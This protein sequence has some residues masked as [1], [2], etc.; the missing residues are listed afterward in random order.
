MNDT[1]LGGI[2]HAL[3]GQAC[4]ATSQDA[5][6][7]M[8][9]DNA[10]KIAEYFAET[11][12]TSPSLGPAISRAMSSREGQDLLRSFVAHMERPPRDLNIGPLNAC[13]CEFQD[14]Q[15]RLQN[16]I[17]ISLLSWG[18]VCS[19]EEQKPCRSGL[20]PLLEPRRER[21]QTPCSKQLVRTKGAPVSLFETESTPQSISI[22]HQWKENIAK[23]MS[24]DAQYHSEAILR[25]VG[26]ICRDLELRCEEAEHPLRME[27]SR[28]RDLE[29][30]LQVSE[31]KLRELALDIE[32]SH[33]QMKNLEHE[34]N[35]L[36][37]QL[38]SSECCLQE[39]RCDLDKAHEE[40]Q[41]IKADAQES[42]KLA[43]ESARKQDLAYLA[44]LTGKDEIQEEQA[45]KLAACEHRARDLEE[46][47]TQLRSQEAKMA[48]K[49]LMDGKV[50]GD[51]RKTH[52]ELKNLLE[53]K[54]A[55]LQCLVNS[56]T[57]LLAKIDESSR[58]AVEVA[59][60]HD[61]VI[62]GLKS[63]LLTAEAKTVQLSEEH[64]VEIAK[65]DAA[66]LH[67]EEQ[68]R[69]T[70]DSVQRELEE[71]RREAAESLAARNT[72]IVELESKTVILRQERQAR[73]RGFAEAQ[74]LS[75][76]LMAIVGTKQRSSFSSTKK[77]RFSCSVDDAVNDNDSGSGKGLQ[78]TKFAERHGSITAQSTRIDD[79]PTPKRARVRRNMTSPL[80]SSAKAII[81]VAGESQR[82]AAWTDRLPLTPLVGPAPNRKA[83]TS[84][85]TG[86]PTKTSLSC[87]QASKGAD[88]NLSERADS[89]DSFGD[90]DIFTSTNQHQLLALRKD[91][92]SSACD[93]TTADL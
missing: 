11:M 21:A 8:E 35:G 47:L 50:I 43:V 32:H 10:V 40:L 87:Y 5:N 90:A 25:M 9:L 80:R 55:D 73:E 22:S 3:L 77:P 51:L 62:V 76:K 26:E 19:R 28:S 71:V 18:L 23:K 58:R 64:R 93:E 70:S 13:L 34:K 17:R 82:G 92:P 7:L 63:Q 33:L 46:S 72:T 91:A 89:D 88:E 29:A 65:K 57:S 37:E 66:F 52:L 31:A 78:G 59:K 30:K 84:R 45:S 2:F 38:K 15:I 24:R 14:T 48:E 53:T 81:S 16:S 1:S 75:R 85:Q 83:M 20:L 27:E 68:A 12:K 49:A 79:S 41:S 42:A 86:S 4:K 69:A 74:D 36:L 61:G 56:K 67:L 39:L 54:D 60:E 44:I 6:V